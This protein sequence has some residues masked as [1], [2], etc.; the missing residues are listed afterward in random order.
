MRANFSR[1]CLAAVL[2]ILP[3]FASAQSSLKA[4]VSFLEGKAVALNV[5]GV[6]RSLKTGD[7]I[8]EGEKIRLETKKSRVVLKV[9]DGTELR[10]KGKTQVGFTEFNRTAS[11]KTRKTRLELAWGTL[12][13]NVAKLTNKSSRFEVKAGGVVCGVRGTTIVGDKN[14]NSNGGHFY[15]IHGSVFVDDGNGPKDL[16]EGMGVE[17]GSNGLGNPSNFN[18]NQFNGFNFGGGGEGGGGDNGGSGGGQ[19]GGNGGLTGSG[20]GGGAGGNGGGGDNGN[21]GGGSGGGGD[22]GSSGGS[23]GLGDLQGGLNDASAQSGDTGRE[24]F[25]NQV[26]N[27]PALGLDFTVPE[28]LG[29]A[30]KAE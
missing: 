22:N 13:A 3:A 6:E 28:G 8:L 2:F 24:T 16:P 18:P 25:N 4:K 27:N 29:G 10:M 26:G 12:W 11:G 20:G 30:E 9:S 17:F 7:T 19:T 23:D 5:K 1:W 15:N 14:A 21:A